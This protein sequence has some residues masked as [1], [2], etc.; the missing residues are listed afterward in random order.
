MRRKRF[1]REFKLEVVRDLESGKSLGEVCRQHNISA[2]MASRWRREYR[3]NPKRAF[4]G[5]GN[6]STAE[7]RIAQLE[8]TVGK[9]YMQNEFLKKAH[10][11]LQQMLAEN[12]ER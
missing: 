7:A 9:L 10:A 6:P 8:R 11:S 3:A 12:K 2:N 1:D 5:Q 4:A